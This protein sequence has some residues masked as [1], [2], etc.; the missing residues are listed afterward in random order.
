MHDLQSRLLKSLMSRPTLA[1]FERFPQHCTKPKVH[2]P[3]CTHTSTDSCTC[4]SMVGLHQA[5]A[6]LPNACQRCVSSMQAMW[7]LTDTTPEYCSAITSGLFGMLSRSAG[8]E[9]KEVH[10]QLVTSKQGPAHSRLVLSVNSQSPSGGD[11][12]IVSGGFQWVSHVAPSTTRDDGSIA[13]DLSQRL[14]HDLGNKILPKHL[15]LSHPL[16]QT[17]HYPRGLG[18]SLENQHSGREICQCRYTISPTCEGDISK[19]H[20]S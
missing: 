5:T 12:V 11:I 17:G 1:S 4:C 19:S 9:M 13:G 18:S 7:R 10:L 16:T 3:S 2:V 15:T 14:R 6:R 20:N 8:I